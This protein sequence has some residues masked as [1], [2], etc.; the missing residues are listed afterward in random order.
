ML[1]GDE[2]L[3]CDAQKIREKLISST[4]DGY[5]FVEESHMSGGAKGKAMAYIKREWTNIRNS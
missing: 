4:V 1:D 3:I 2:R 5:D